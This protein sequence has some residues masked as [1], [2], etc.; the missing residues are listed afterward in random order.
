MYK[1]LICNLYNI[2][3]VYFILLNIFFLLLVRVVFLYFAMFFDLG[4]QRLCSHFPVVVSVYKK[5][6]VWPL[7][8]LW[9]MIEIC[10]ILRFC[11]LGVCDL[12]WCRLGYS[13]GNWTILLWCV[14]W[15]CYE[16]IDSRV[17]V[18][19]FVLVDMVE[20]FC[21]CVLESVRFLMGC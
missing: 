9:E 4:S 15:E 20:L 14:M 5:I 10:S 17:F 3:S 1:C 8:L 7:S 18:F 2:Y 12:S 13:A 19:I 6:V 11:N 16:D 21:V